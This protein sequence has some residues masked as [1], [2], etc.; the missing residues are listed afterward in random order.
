[1]RKDYAREAA[2]LAKYF[3]MHF[4]KNKQAALFLN[5]VKHFFAES[6]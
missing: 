5:L 4:I 6:K 2:T 1:M 3:S